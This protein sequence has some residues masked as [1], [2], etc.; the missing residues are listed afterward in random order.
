MVY[1]SEEGKIR[2]I[3]REILHYYAIGRPQL[4]GTTSVEHSE[5]LS[6]RLGA[7]PLRRLAQTLIIRDAWMEKFDKSF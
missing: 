2:A 3:T 1:R 4:I 7:E 5:R 6:L